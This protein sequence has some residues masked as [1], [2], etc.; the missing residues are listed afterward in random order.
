M[1]RRLLAATALAA[2]AFG[3]VAT[4]PAHAAPGGQT[5]VGLGTDREPANNHMTAI[6][7]RDVVGGGH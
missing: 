1:T 3:A 6:C 4:I 2:A 7:L 5:C